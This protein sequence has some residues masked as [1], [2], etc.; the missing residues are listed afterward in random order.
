MVM[1]LFTEW[2]ILFKERRTLRRH[3]R[4]TF[5]RIS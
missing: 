4:R 5:I 3:S 2:T 1:F